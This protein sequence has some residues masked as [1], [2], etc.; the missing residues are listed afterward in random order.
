MATDM[1]VRAASTE[2]GTSRRRFLASVG[3]SGLALAV[4][5]GTAA[6]QSSP[7]GGWFDNVSNYDG[8]VD[9]TGQKKVTVKVGSEANGGGFGFSPPAIKVDPGT[10]VVWEWTGQGGSHNVE[11]D[12]GSFKSKLTGEAGF[13]FEHTFQNEG[14]HKYYCMPHQAMG[15]KGA[16]AVGDV[17]EAGAGD[18][19]VG[20]GTGGSSSGSGSVTSGSTGGSSGSGGDGS[21]AGG[22]SGSDTASAGGSSATDSGP[23]MGAVSIAIAF[24]L[25]FLSPIAFAG[26][27]QTRDRE[28]LE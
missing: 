6:A 21:N 8:T 11:A 25:A 13:T 28:D 5:A 7:Y 14:I 20:S 23:A 15:M 2:E 12:D 4:G 19:S 9:K 1:R 17:V 26:F 16:V 27:L 24:V 10:T 18:S 22:S 3:A